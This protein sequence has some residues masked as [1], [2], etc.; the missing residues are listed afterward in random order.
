MRNGSGIPEFFKHAWDVGRAIATREEQSRIADGMWRRWKSAY[1][2]DPNR[3]PFG[4]PEADLDPRAV[5]DATPERQREVQA[6]AR[7]DFEAAVKA[8][9]PVNTGQE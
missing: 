5:P 6:Q 9:R 7:T 4:P 3:K 1:L 2:R 8:S